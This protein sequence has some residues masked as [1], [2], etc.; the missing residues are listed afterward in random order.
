MIVQMCITAST[1]VVL[2]PKALAYVSSFFGGILNIFEWNRKKLLVENL[3][4]YVRI[5]LFYA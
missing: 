1:N 5:D 3:I 4:Y 2:A